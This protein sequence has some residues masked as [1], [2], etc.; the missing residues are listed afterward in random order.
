MRQTFIPSDINHSLMTL[1]Q[2]AELFAQGNNAD[3]FY[4]VLS[5]SVDIYRDKEMVMKL[6]PE[7]VLG[8]EPLFSPQGS[9]LYTAKSSDAVRL[10]KY[11][12]LELLDILGTQPVVLKQILNSIFGQLTDFWAGTDARQG[13]VPAH[14]F[15]GDIR[16]YQP[17]QWVIREGEYDTEIFRIVSTDRGLEV[18]KK[19]HKLTVLQ[20]QGEFFGEMAAILNEKRSAS[21]RSL[22]N[23]ILEVYPGAHLQKIFTD[24]PQVSMRIISALSQRLAETTRALIDREQ[25]P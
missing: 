4:I 25:S 6:G 19:G 11:T 7:S 9:Y 5:G 8:A 10:S 22:G 1:E 15:S 16:S 17:D 2:G 18:S 21:V 12:Y 20:N 3:C 14:H 23:S 13:N 24:Y